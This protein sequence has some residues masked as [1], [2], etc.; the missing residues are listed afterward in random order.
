[1][2][3]IVLVGRVLLVLVALGSGMAGHFG[4]TDATAAYAES[5]GV[6]NGHM[7]VR[8]S[9]V[10]LI[11]AALSV[12][13]GIYPDLGAL[14]FAA[15]ALVA[16]YVIHHFW[17]DDDEM[18]K[19]IEMTNFMKN[20]SITGGSLM[21]FAYFVTLGEAAPFQITANLFDF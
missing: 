9:G 7:W 2:D 5:R 11:V 21:A 20:L 1:M 4:A 10:W 3:I 13:L 17:T 14:M 12:I 15:F 6:K 18:T 19:Q 16:A 8:V